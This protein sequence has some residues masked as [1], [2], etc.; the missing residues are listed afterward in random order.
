MFPTVSRCA[1]L[2]S[3]FKEAATKLPQ[4]RVDREIAEHELI[5]RLFAFWD[6]SYRGA[7]S[8]QVGLAVHDIASHIDG[9]A[10]SDQWG[11]WRYV[12]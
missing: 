12:Q 9:I 8:F 4:S 1:S 3:L 5:D 7:L 6:T 2:I 11:G 10:G